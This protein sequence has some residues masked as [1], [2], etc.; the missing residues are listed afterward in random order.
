MRRLLLLGSNHERDHYLPLAK[1]GLGARFRIVASS[2]IYTS[3]AVGP[4]VAPDGS[5]PDFYN[6][7]V[8]IESDLQALELRAKLRA[9]EANLG[10][11]RPRKIA[12]RTAQL[13][14]IDIDMV[15][16]L[17]RGGIAGR[18]HHELFRYHHVAVPCA[19]LIGDQVLPGDGRTCEQVARDLGPWPA[20]MAALQESES[21]RPSC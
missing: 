20:G 14:T 8:I 2:R 3:P 10:R 7:A 17:E 18:A 11:V 1:A 5:T 13:R 6:Q 12:R 15:L 4:S 21:S 16:D 9:L 19:D